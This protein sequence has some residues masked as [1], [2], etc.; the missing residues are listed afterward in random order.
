MPMQ[1]QK[2]IVWQ[3]QVLDLLV[4]QLWFLNHDCGPMRF[5]FPNRAFFLTIVVPTQTF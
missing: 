5:Q 2:E 4:G 3:V 1:L